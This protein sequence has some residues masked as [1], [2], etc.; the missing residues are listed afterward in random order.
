MAFYELAR[1]HMRQCHQN[2]AQDKFSNDLIGSFDFDLGGIWSRPGHELYR[3]W[4]ALCMN[5][6]HEEKQAK[7]KQKAKSGIQGFLK[8]SVSLVPDGS[9]MVHEHT[10]HVEDNELPW[11]PAVWGRALSRALGLRVSHKVRT[12]GGGNLHGRTH[13]ITQF[14][15]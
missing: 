14:C 8:L 6:A 12:G 15:T 9:K 4:V 1:A 11:D 13:R 3:H 5:D 7:T 10:G 2:T